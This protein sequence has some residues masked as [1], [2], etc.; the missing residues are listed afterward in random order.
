MSVPYPNPELI[1]VWAT[2]GIEAALIHD[3]ALPVYREARHLVPVG[4]GTDGRDKLL[5]P[6]AAAAWTEMKA[7]AA[8]D[9]IELLLISGF[10]SYA[11]QAALIEYK[12]RRGDTLDAVLRINAPPG[13]SEH[14]T[15]RALDIGFDGCP[16][17][18][19]DFDKT[20][21]YAW[22]R[23]NARCFGFRLSYP[24]NNPQGY[25]YEPWHWYFSGHR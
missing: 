3:R 11:Y 20:A 23:R 12:L 2:L 9:C 18:D 17:L 13:C 8:R 1:P 21:A 4:L 16:A 10:R 24:Q 7:A 6:G 15:G 14:H 5:S 19:A 22:L 25:L